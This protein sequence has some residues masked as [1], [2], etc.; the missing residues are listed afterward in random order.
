MQRTSRPQRGHIV[1]G[2]RFEGRAAGLRPYGAGHEGFG[3][4][5]EVGDGGGGG[6]EGVD[7][8]GLVAV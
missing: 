1:R 4:G 5:D 7:G 3:V 8:F 2:G 6:V